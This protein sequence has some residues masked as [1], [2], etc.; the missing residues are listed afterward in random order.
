MYYKLESP[1]SE[2]KK[3][4]II[5]FILILIIILGLIYYDKQLDS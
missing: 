2:N 4:T 5:Y 3:V 1:V